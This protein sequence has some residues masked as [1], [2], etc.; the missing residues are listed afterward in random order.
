MN[1][2]K[3]KKTKKTKKQKAVNK[4][5]NKNTNKNVININIDNS[6]K[7]AR[8]P[9]KPKKNNQDIPPPQQILPMGSTQHIIIDRN[10]RTP[11]IDNY[12]QENFKNNL[13]EQQNRFLSQLQYYNL[14][15]QQS[16]TADLLR[17]SANNPQSLD[18]Q[19]E[20][21]QGAI[22][23]EPQE[24]Q[25]NILKIQNKRVRKPKDKTVYYINN[26][27]KPVNKKG[28]VVSRP[29]KNALFK[30]GNKLYTYEEYKEG[31][32]VLLNQQKNKAVDITQTPT[33][34]PILLAPP[35]TP[36]TPPI[37]PDVSA[38]QK[39]KRTRKAKTTVE[40]EKN[41]I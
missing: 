12:V 21:E 17:L 32:A 10:D 33:K 31:R 6:K 1:K 2:T 40:T 39:V 35:T 19:Q 23:E 18:Y 28:D 29:S 27:Y 11:L 38:P 14:L 34:E 41:N 4:N 3:S 37:I 26:D 7:T 5:K 25:P 16:N 9:T 15:P 20:E 8:K 36:A 30:F 24:P 13:L 22:V